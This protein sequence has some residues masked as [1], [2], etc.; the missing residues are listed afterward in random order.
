MLNDEKGIIVRLK[1]QNRFAVL[2]SLDDG[3]C[4]SGI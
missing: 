2:E 4:I 1:S 3:G